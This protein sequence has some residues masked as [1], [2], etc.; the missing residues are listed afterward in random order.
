MKNSHGFYFDLAGFIP[1]FLLNNLVQSTISL[2][3]CR[4]F[5]LP[6]E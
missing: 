6:K 2:T 5:M 4:T 3:F 1:A